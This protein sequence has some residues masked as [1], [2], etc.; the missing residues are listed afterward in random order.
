SGLSLIL[1]NLENEIDLPAEILKRLIVEQALAVGLIA[2]ARICVARDL[3]KAHYLV[4]AESHDRIVDPAL[5]QPQPVVMW[6]AVW[7]DAIAV[8]VDADSGPLLEPSPDF[9]PGSDVRNCLSLEIEGEELDPNGSAMER[10]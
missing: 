5:I 3:Y 4:V 1:V 2:Q 7:P 6:L 10:R 9:H 8:S